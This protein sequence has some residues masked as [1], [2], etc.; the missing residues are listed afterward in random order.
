MAE[1]AVVPGGIRSISRPA[2]RLR[3]TRSDRACLLVEGWLPSLEA[4]RDSLNKLTAQSAC[5]GSAA[6]L[7]QLGNLPA[8]FRCLASTAQPQVMPRGCTEA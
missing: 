1:T 4:R 7:V 6:S 5:L 3:K 2:S 8:A